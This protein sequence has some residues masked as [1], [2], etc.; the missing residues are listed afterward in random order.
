MNKLLV[1]FSLLMLFQMINAQSSDDALLSVLK[2]RVGI[3]K[4][5]Q[6]IVIAIIDE[7]E[8][9]F[10]SFGKTN[11]NVD[12]PD[13]DENTV[14]EIGS[15]TK[16]FTGILLAEAVKRGEVK[17]ND[18]VSKHLP[19]T[20]KVPSRNGKEITLLDL[21]THTSGLPRLPSNFAPKDYLN[22]YADYT[23]Q[24]MYDF[25]SNYELPRD[26][27]KE[28]EYSNL[29]MG[30]LGYILSLK[31]GT[32]YENLIKTRILLPLE[33]FDTTITL[34]PAQKTRIA[35]GFD[36]N[37]E[38]TPLWDL[39]TLAGS[40]A[41]RSTAKDMA[42]FV[43]YLL[44]LEKS[45]LLEVFN[46]S[47]K[48]QFTVNPQTKIGL[49]WHIL[50]QNP[51][52][53]IIWHNGGTGGF[54]SF[55]AFSKTEKRGVVVLSN[56][57]ENIDDIG[58]Y[59]LD[60]SNPL[61]KFKPDFAVSETLLEEYS[62]KYELA[63]NVVFTISTEE[64]KLYAQITNQQRFRIFAE[65]E[66]KF[67]YKVVTAKLTFNRDADGKIESLTLTQNGEHIAKRIK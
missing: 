21:A 44:D 33:L 30:L 2:E 42:K 59:I 36:I 9:K 51:D 7:K 24:N 8:T 39:G 46:E 15:I 26:I 48:T 62:G 55:L 37:G 29:G 56:S 1:V 47:E 65:A 61:K 43:K 18:S 31:A 53:E 12:S 38:K 60:S 63:P 64:G 54:S 28:Y 23:V 50:Q 11:Q 22:P 57:A 19:S 27:G 3:G 67:Y 20:I 5:N 4:V 41:L 40:G 66:N 25:L 49:G 35:Q 13:S 10:T 16:A 32:T 6:S 34:F 45:S 14:F 17:L 58:L 52:K